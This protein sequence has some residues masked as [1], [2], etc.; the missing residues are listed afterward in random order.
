MKRLLLALVLA[1]V[2]TFAESGKNRAEPP[3]PG[4]APVVEDNTP[5]DPNKFAALSLLGDRVQLLSLTPARGD[6]VHS[7]EW[8]ATPA[9]AL[10]D[11]VL[12]AINVTIKAVDDKRE[13]KLYTASTRSLF[14]DPEALFVDGKLALPGNLGVAVRKSGAATLLV[15]TRSPQEAALARA[16]PARI[17]TTLDGPGFVLDQRPSDQIGFD[18]RP[19]QPV[20]AP[21]VSIRVALIDLAD[22]K[23][24]REQSL[25]VASR[26]PLAADA[27]GNPWAATTPEQR[28]NA[29]EALISA[30]L[31]IAMKGLVAK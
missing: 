28:V 14:G 15:V 22:M 13:V 7:G 21:F 10:D 30:E 23:L 3:P 4:P 20:F 18:G 9:G 25:V 6:T 16:L 31:P 24:R 11:A 1:P 19:R 12:Q 8:T 29:L 27:V 2:L 17:L 26:L 5:R